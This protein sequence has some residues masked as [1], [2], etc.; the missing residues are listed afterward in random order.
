MNTARAFGPA[1]VTGFPYG[2]HWVVR[3]SLPCCLSTSRIG[4]V[5]GWSMPGVIPGIGVLCDLEAVRCQIISSRVI[6]ND[7]CSSVAGTTG[8][9]TRTKRSRM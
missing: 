7:G 5:L 9:S 8:S 1:V 4:S 2:T 3:V 6:C